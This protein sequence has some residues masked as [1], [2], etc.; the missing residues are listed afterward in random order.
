M[1]DVKQDLPGDA[2]RRDFLR[3]G[4]MAAVALS[5]PEL[6]AEATKPHAGTMIGMPFTAGNPRIGIIGTGGR[7]TSL[8]ENL[9]AADAQIHALCDVVREKA[10]HAQGLVTKV[11]QK[12]PEL[13]TDGDHAFEALV[14]RDDLD[15]QNYLRREGWLKDDQMR[16]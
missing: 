14:A 9:L 7:G 8:L 10:E 15:L 16:P 5:V 2:S 13:Y 3:L 6:H 1:S 4:G 11:G 12:A